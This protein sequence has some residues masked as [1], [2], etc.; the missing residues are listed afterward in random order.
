MSRNIRSSLA[1]T[2]LTLLALSSACQT[3][4]VSSRAETAGPLRGAGAASL[5]PFIQGASK[6]FVEEHPKVRPQIAEARSS[7]AIKKLIDG[8]V[9]FAFTSRS[10]RQADLDDGAKQH[11]DLHMVVMGAEALA[12]IV[13]PSNPLR[14]VSTEVLRDVFFSGKIRDWSTL[15]DGKKTGPIRVFAVNPKTSGT[16]ELFVTL[17]DGDGKRPYISQATLVD[18]SDGTIA[19][20]GGDPEAISFSGMANVNAQVSSV[21]VNGVVPAEKTILDTSY[22]LN[23]KLFFISAGPPRGTS[24]EFVK[25]LLSEPGQ[26]LARVTGVTPITLD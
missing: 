20:V 10:L 9:D 26:R 18:Y 8:E 4:V 6:T 2:A 21:T 16:G 24:R 19:K 23:R 17:V 12:V 5:L 3:A 1:A 13:H 11:R 14:D 7:A 25:F 15:T 22:M